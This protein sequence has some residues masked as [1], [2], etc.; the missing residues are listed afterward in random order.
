MKR[1]IPV[2]IFLLLAI[3]LAVGLTLDPK[4]VPSP[5]V[6]KSAPAFALPTLAQPDAQLNN[7]SF[8]G[9]ISLLNVW[10]TWCVSC[11]QEHEVLNAI[12]KTNKVTLY[13]LNYKDDRTA[14]LQWLKRYGNPYQVSGFDQDGR[15]GIDWGVYGTPETFLID[16]QGVIRHKVIGPISIKIWQEE[17]LPMIEALGQ[18]G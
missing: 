7:D 16:Q 10:A 11:R 14:A 6:G 15:V 8:K 12:A 2:I 4:K 3:L 1:F 9:K 13:G 17:L 18:A 5:L